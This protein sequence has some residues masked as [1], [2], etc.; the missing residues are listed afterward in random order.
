MVVEILA[1]TGKRMAH[2]DAL[3]CQQVRIADPRQL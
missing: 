2:S 3:R 1:D